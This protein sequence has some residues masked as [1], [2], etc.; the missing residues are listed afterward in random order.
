MNSYSPIKDEQVAYFDSGTL[1]LCD[2][3]ISLTILTISTL[4]L[5]FYNISTCQIHFIAIQ[6]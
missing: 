5:D 2:Q 4:C 6:Q 1:F 3:Y